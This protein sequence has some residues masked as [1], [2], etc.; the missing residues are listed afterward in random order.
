MQVLHKLPWKQKYN[1]QSPN[2]WPNRNIVEKKKGKWEQN[3]KQSFAHEVLSLFAKNCSQTK[4]NHAILAKLACCSRK[5]SYIV[6]R[7]T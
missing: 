3:Q 5:H 7:I 6:I 1:M 2:A 4:R